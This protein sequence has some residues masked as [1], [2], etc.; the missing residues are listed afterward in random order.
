MEKKKIAFF[1]PTIDIGG[2]EINTLNLSYSI[3]NQFGKPLLIYLREKNT[4]LKR[5]FSET[6]ALV[7]MKDRRSIFLFLSF[8]EMIKREK[9]EIIVISSFINLIHLTLLKK[10]FYFDLKIIF[11]VET[12]LERDLRNQSVIDLILFKLFKNFSFKLCDLVVCSC[13][14]LQQSFLRTVKIEPHKLKTIY[15]PVVKNEHLNSNYKS[16]EHRF[17]NE[18]NPDRKVFISIGRLVESKGFSELIKT[19]KKYISIK[20]DQDAKLL[21]VGIGPLL[22]QLNQ[23]IESLNIEDSVEIIPFNNSFVRFIQSSDVFVSN[24]SYEGL[25][26]NIVHALS[27]G[28]KIIATDCEFGPRE[29]LLDGKLGTLIQPGN[30]DELLKAMQNI[31]ENQGASQERLIERSKDFSI[32]KISEKFIS[33]IDSV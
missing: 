21:I 11:K 6:M 2:V 17:F 5:E 14:S 12:N 24:S 25:N 26:N 8:K 15:N 3:K 7:K 33:M 16:A 22:D 32:D 23:L 28:K 30:Q 4:E 10:F 20:E 1:I 18:L 13:N 31:F 29:V 9:P 27:Q 19:F